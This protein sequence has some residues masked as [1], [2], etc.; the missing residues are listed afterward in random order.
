[1]KVKRHKRRL[2][3]KALTAMYGGAIGELR[4]LDKEIGHAIAE[5]RA[6]GVSPLKDSHVKHLAKKEIAVLKRIIA[7]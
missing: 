1:M 3:K 2:S 7:S 4:V 6:E 5:A